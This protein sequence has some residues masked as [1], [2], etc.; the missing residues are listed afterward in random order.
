MLVGKGFCSQF[1]LSSLTRQFKVDDVADDRTPG[2]AY[3]PDESFCLVPAKD[4]AII[5]CD[6]D[7]GGVVTVL[8]G[9]HSTV[10][11]I[12]FSAAFHNFVSAGK[13]CLFWTVD[14]ATYNALIAQ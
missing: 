2:F 7:K 9:H 13:E 11:A 3:S 4:N 12:K 1:H 14:V 5:V 8:S 10:G 6:T